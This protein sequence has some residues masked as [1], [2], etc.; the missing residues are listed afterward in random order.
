MK[1]EVLSEINRVNELMGLK[2]LTEG[3]I[4]TAL[5]KKVVKN[6]GSSSDEVTQATFK[7]A[8]RKAGVPESV[9]DDINKILD[10]PDNADELY[11]ALAPGA[12]RQI[13]RTLAEVDEIASELYDSV[14]DEIGVAASDVTQALANKVRRFKSEAD[15]AGDVLTDEQAY[16]K[17]V[18]ELIGEGGPEEVLVLFKKQN[19]KATMDVALNKVNKYTKRSDVELDADY[20]DFKVRANKASWTPSEDDFALAQ[21]LIKRN[22]MSND[23]WLKMLGSKVPGWSELMGLHDTYKYLRS[24]GDID[25]AL[26]FTDWLTDTASK[27]VPGW[28]TKNSAVFTNRFIRKYKIVSG[29]VEATP[30]QIRGAWLALVF[31]MS[32]VSGLLGA[33]WRIVSTGSE[34]TVNWLED[35]TGVNELELKNRW[36]GYWESDRPLFKIGSTEISAYNEQDLENNKPFKN[37]PPLMS[38]MDAKAGI[39]SLEGNQKVSIQ[40]ELYDNVKFILAKTMLLDVGAGSSLFPDFI[41]PVPKG[42]SGTGEFTNDIEGFKNFLLSKG[43]PSEGATYKETTGIYYTEN[44]IDY[45]YDSQT[46]TF[47]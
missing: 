38:V 25:K 36:D 33:L 18:I 46:K 32:L 27:R 9:L 23:T 43:I 17:A 26:S 6:L 34:G 15:A 7:T 12:K 24:N 4:G 3:G 35:L 19:Y 47:K 1:K 40:G 5:R 13:M 10:N 2:L 37:N 22:K 41:S 39:V 20:A 8:A 16:D 31:D 44:G 42:N 45:E 21:E 29:M 30:A 11:D 14:L 28:W